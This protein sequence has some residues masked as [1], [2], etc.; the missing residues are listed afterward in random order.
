MDSV[1]GIALRNC[2]PEGPLMIQIVKLY[3]ADNVNTFDAFGRVL[4]GTIK[5]NDS[6]NVLGEGYSPDDEENMFIKQVT[7]LSIYES[8]YKVSVT[9]VPCGNWVLISGIDQ[10]IIKTATIT[11]NLDYVHT[12]QPL[13]FNTQPVLKIAVEPVNPTELPKMLEGLRKINKSYPILT[14]KVEESG[15]HI[16]LGPGELYLDCAMHDL[17]KLYAEIDI[18][19]SDPVVTFCETVVDTSSLKCFA[20]TPNKKNK[21]TMICEPLEKG[22]ADDIENSVISVN[23]PKVQLGKHFVDSYNWDILSSR[24][25]WAFGPT[26]LSPN[27][28]VNDTLPSEVFLDQHFR[29]IRNFCSQL[30]TPLGKGFSG[31]LAKVHWLMNVTF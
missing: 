24:N 10:S 13:R 18:K 25:I 12:F 5:V 3:N 19:V 16:I 22:I 29:P 31:A 2:D 14:T 8:R 23:W 15:E 28:L 30:K 6:V 20:L 4:S 1:H 7:G 9:K 17:R 11:D 26:D 27:I 21:L